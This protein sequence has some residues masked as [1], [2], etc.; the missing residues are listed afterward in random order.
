MSSKRLSRLGALAALLLMLTTLWTPGPA[1]AVD[2][3]DAGPTAPNAATTA[4]AD[5]TGAATGALLS[6]AASSDRRVVLIL[7]PFLRWE[8]IEATTTPQLW[9]AARTGAVGDINARSRVKE[10]DGA[11]SLAEGVLTI[12]SG[13]WPYVDAVAYAAFEGS[14]LF[15]YTKVSSAYKRI[16]SG[17]M[18]DDDIAYLGL[19]RTVAA[20]AG[21][22]FTVIPGTLGSAIEAAGGVTAAIG[23]SDLGYSTDVQRYLRPAALAA[24][25]ESGFV[26]YGAISPELLKENSEM[27]YGV[28]TDLEAMESEMALVADELAP[29]APGLLVVDPGDGYRARTAAADAVAS[30]ADEQ[31]LFSLGVLD[32]TYGLARQYFPEATIIVA[33]QASRS[34]T[35]EREGF[36]PLL[37][38]GPGISSGLLSSDSTHRVGL[39]TNLDLTATIL[40]LC[41]VDQPVQVLGTQL[42]LATADSEGPL[43]PGR[44]PTGAAADSDLALASRLD[45]LK[46]MNDTAISVEVMR[47]VIMSTTVWAAVA[48]LAAGALVVT[49]AERR[50]RSL[51]IG[52]LKTAL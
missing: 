41:G 35:L 5:K 31:W 18:E 44:L 30:V 23:N 7:A 27:P 21:N 43:T 36:G 17:N 39:V 22:S 48:V 50:W 32:D 46:K 3:A 14:E 1:S 13:A 19:P 40:A 52:I 47:P 25:N 37:V 29:A 2:V 34:W 8:D 16:L 51:T 11:P 45:L 26:H 12:S 38:T 20:N 24:M 9:E 42:H 6:D 4:D 33:S 15:G 10:E 28:Q 49:F